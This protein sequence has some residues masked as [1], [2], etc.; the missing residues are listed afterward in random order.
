MGLIGMWKVFVEF[1]VIGLIGL[2]CLCMVVVQVLG[3]VFIVWVWEV[4]KCYVEKW[5]DVL[6]VVVGICVLG[7]IGDF[8]I[9]D[10]VCEFVGFV[11][12]VGDFVIIVVWDCIVW[13]DGLLFCFEG[14]VMAVVW[15]VVVDIGL[16]ED[17]DCCVLFNCVMGLKYLMLI[18]NVFLDWY[19]LIDWV[20]LIQCFIVDKFYVGC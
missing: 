17:I 5:E 19:W 7:V 6:I 4:G 8:L 1:E 16:I 11:I 14:V 12:V 20:F 10:V 18:V 2:E 3:C 13:E 15:E 9:F